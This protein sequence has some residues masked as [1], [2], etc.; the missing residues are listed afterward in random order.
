MLRKVL[1]FLFLL[2]NISGDNMNLKKV[3]L[4]D[5]PEGLNDLEKARFIYLKLALY[6]DFSTKYNNTNSVEFLKMS[7]SG[8]NPENQREKQ[9]ICK[10]WA[11][12]Y[13]SLLTEAGV[14]NKVIDQHHSYVLFE[15][16]GKVWVADATYGSY[17]DLSRIRYGD[18]T[19][20]FGVCVSQDMNKPLN[21]VVPFNSYNRILDEIDKKFDFYQ[22]K[23]ESFKKLQS[24]L[25][26]IKNSDKS[27][28][29]KLDLFFELVGVLD[30]GYYEAKDFVRNLEYD[31]FNDS[32]LSRIHGVELKRTN[33]NLEVDI[34]QCI[35]VEQE[36]GYS[37]YL[38]APDKT[39]KKVTPLEITKLATLGYGIE[40]KEIP[41]VVF[42]R[43]FQAGVP[44]KKGLMYKVSRNFV[45]NKIID[46]EEEQF[47][48]Y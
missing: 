11:H 43:R 18:S 38:L 39:V 4:D 30:E 47:K 26:E 5:M 6:L 32:E 15:Y 45:P 42:P 3:I 20:Y 21:H 19:F 14:K 17:T 41:G 25:E 34:V 37:Y 24:K 10:N 12:I 16:D 27:I 13:S 9:I 46:Y 36:N 31:I 35:Y 48:T 28:R 1:T 7:Y 40:G 22:V 2:Y 29:Q 44:F 23:R 33:Q 8:T